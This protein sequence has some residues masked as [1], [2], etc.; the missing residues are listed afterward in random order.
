MRNVSATEPRRSIGYCGGPS[1]NCTV[2]FCRI[3]VCKYPTEPSRAT[4]IQHVVLSFGGEEASFRFLSQKNTERRRA[5]IKTR[6]SNVLYRGELRPRPPKKLGSMCSLWNRSY[7][8]ATQSILAAIKSLALH[9]LQFTTS[10]PHHHTVAKD[11]ETHPMTTP[12][13][14]VQE[15]KGSVVAIVKHSLGHLVQRRLD[16]FIYLLLPGT[17]AELRAKHVPILEALCP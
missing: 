8:E 12:G 11:G 14:P 6:V 10:F 16:C 7:K 5:W 15:T 13:N 17:V 3:Q 4:I 2:V 9:S 1:Q